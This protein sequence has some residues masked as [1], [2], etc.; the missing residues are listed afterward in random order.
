MHGTDKLPCPVY[1]AHSDCLASFIAD[2]IMETPVNP[3]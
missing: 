3:T 2:F 1:S